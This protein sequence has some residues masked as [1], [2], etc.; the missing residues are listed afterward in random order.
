MLFFPLLADDQ[1]SPV[2]APWIFLKA[3]RTGYI[4]HVGLEDGFLRLTLD[5]TYDD[6]AL[7]MDVWVTG[8]RSPARA[9]ILYD[10]KRILSLEIEKYDIR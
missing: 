10:G 7:Q 9:D 1:L 2:C 8:E 6:D 3:L 4:C 5:D